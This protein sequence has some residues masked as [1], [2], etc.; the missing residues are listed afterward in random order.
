MFIVAKE[1]D[2]KVYIIIPV[3]VG[4]VC[5]S[6]MIFVAWC[7]MMKRKGTEFGF[8]FTIVGD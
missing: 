7:W 1:K 5:I 8:F 2:K 4:F 3:V 6:A